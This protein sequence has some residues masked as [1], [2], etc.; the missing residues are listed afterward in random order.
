VILIAALGFANY[1]LLK[2]HGARGAGAGAILASL[3]SAIVNL[4][5]VARRAKDRGLN[6]RLAWALGAVVLLGVTATVLQGYLHWQPASLATS[7]SG[8]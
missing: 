4:P 2:L 7:R 5:L 8:D 1:V 6:R 3:M